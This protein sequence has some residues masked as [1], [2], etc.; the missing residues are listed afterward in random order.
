MNIIFI[1]TLIN[2]QPQTTPSQYECAEDEYSIPIT[3]T[4]SS[5]KKKINYCH[6]CSAAVAACSSCNVSSGNASTYKVVCHSCQQEYQL[7]EGMCQQKGSAAPI[8][9]TAVVLGVVVVVVGAIFAIVFYRK[10]VFYCVFYWQMIL[11]L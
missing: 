9:I 2:L 1:E 7:H 11:F 8:W 4:I 3:S 10:V 5:K 6:R